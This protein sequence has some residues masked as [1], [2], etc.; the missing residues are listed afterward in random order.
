MKYDFFVASRYR[1]KEEV[2]RLVHAIREKGKSAYCFI[3]SEASLKHVGKLD[4]NAQEQMTRYELKDW[5]SDE[6]IRE[7]FEMDMTALKNSKAIVV[8]L[9]AGKSVH[10]EAGV[11]YGMGKECILIGEQKEAESLYLIF[12]KIYPIIDEFIK[13]L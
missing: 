4:E 7:I 12:N 1:N 10:I 5:K 9:P 13:S 8:L 11:A 6:G 3:E 2:L